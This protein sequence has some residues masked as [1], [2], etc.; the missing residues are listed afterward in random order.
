MADVSVVV[1]LHFSECVIF[2]PFFFHVTEIGGVPVY[3]HSKIKFFPFS[4]LISFTF[5]TNLAGSIINNGKK[6]N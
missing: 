1:M 3:V 6:T 5:F 2:T 4:T